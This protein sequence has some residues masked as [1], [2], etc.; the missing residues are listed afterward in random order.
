M[1]VRPE[2]ILRTLT[3]N[4]ERLYKQLVPVIDQALMQ[5]FDGTSRVDVSL[6]V[7][8]PMRPALKTRLTTVYEAHG[9]KV[10]FTDGYQHNDYWCSASFEARTGTTSGR[11]ALPDE[12]ERTLRREA[13]AGDRE[14]QDRLDGGPDLGGRP[15]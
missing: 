1:P 12:E 7:S 10:K 15:S 8:S 14:A 9:W 11:L 13:A 3:E 4:D 5:R 2:E 6:C